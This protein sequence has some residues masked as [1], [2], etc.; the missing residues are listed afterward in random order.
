MVFDVSTSKDFLL[1][2]KPEE[3]LDRED[4]SAMGGNLKIYII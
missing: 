1:V 3:F 4:Q 2:G